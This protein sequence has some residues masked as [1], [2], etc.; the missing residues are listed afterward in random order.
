[1]SRARAKAHDIRSTLAYKE[2]NAIE[3]MIRLA[4]SDSLD[5]GEGRKNSVLYKGSPC[6]K[7]G[8]MVSWL[9]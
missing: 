8:V 2:L 6:Q 9:S 7:K 3:L 5:L 1:M 4:T